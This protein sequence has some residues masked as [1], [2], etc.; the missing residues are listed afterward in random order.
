MHVARMRDGQC[1]QKYGLMIRK[2][3][4]RLEDIFVQRWILLKLTLNNKCQWTASVV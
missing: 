4:K 1:T 2:E 3:D